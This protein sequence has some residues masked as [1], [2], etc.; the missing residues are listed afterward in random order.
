MMLVRRLG[1]A[2]MRV[3]EIEVPDEEK[4]KAAGER[5]FSAVL[6]KRKREVEAPLMRS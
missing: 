2:A 6:G 4:A 3:A 5:C 1:A